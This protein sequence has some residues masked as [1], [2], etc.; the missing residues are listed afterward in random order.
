MN[1][2]S[3]PVIEMEE[4]TKIFYTDEVETQ[5]VSG[6]DLTIQKGEYVCVAGPSGCGKSTLLS[7]AGLL[8]TPTKGKYHLNGQAVED[9]APSQ[10]ALQMKLPFEEKRF[11][12]KTLSAEIY[13]LELARLLEQTRSLRDAVVS[14][15]IYTSIE[16]LDELRIFMEHHVF[17]VWDF[18]SLVKER[19]CSSEHP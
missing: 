11:L 10:M 8:D 7:I 17:A 2:E 13:G 15:G 16:N 14:H 5:A 4:V 3:A 18:M 12:E 9:L 1:T 19:V 6:I